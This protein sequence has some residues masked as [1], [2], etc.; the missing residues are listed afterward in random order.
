MDKLDKL[1]G[2]ILLVLFV[3]LPFALY[4]ISRLLP[5]SKPKLRKDKPLRTRG[6][7]DDSLATGLVDVMITD[8]WMRDH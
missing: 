4:W 7:S 1:D 2:F 5:P 6:H 3:A 8:M